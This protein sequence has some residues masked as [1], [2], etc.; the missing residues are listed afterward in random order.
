[1]REAVAVMGR[2]AHGQVLVGSVAVRPRA[3][4]TIAVMLVVLLAPAGCKL[5]VRPPAPVLPTQVTP[6][7]GA[8]PGGAFPGGWHVEAAARFRKPSSYRLVDN[9][10]M[11]V[12]EGT[13]DRSASGLVEFVDIDPNERPI[14]TWRWKITQPIEGADTTQ[15]RGDDA[16]ARVMLSF[17]GDMQS[18]SF[19]DRLWSNQVK[20][21]SGIT[22]PYATLEYVW[23]AGAPKGTVVI[24]SYTARIRTMLVENSPQPLNEWITETRD[25]VEDF[26]RAFGEEPG[27]ITAVALYT[28]GDATGARSQGYYGDL[29]FV[30]RSEAQARA[31][32]R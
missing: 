1:M 23:G 20:L 26:R 2:R 29:K 8:P 3:A 5:F 22:V 19:S 14:L 12:V 13:A 7:S 24:N 4:R 9:G 32:T 28:D 30:T 15:R 6:F 11:T 17:A 18:L 16:P 25:V 27:H 21:I 31:A 10:G